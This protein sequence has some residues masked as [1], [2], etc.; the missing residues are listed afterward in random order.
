MPESSHFSQGILRNGAYFAAMDPIQ[1]SVESL[2]AE[3]DR[4]VTERQEL[5]RNCASD[6]ELELNRRRLVRAQSQLSQLLIQR[7]LPGP[8]AA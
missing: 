8:A 6:E 4:L 7:H 1:H 3:I 2:R 5:R